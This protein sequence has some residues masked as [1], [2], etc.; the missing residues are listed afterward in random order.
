M[1]ATAGSLAA[2]EDGTGELKL[3][4]V[5]R[6]RRGE[7]EGSEERED[8]NLHFDGGRP[9]EAGEGMRREEC[10]QSFCEGVFMGVHVGLG[11]WPRLTTKDNIVWHR[12]MHS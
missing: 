11:L 1:V 9:R 5:D 6:R 10:G 12:T 7:G 8:R 4:R 2:L 3:G